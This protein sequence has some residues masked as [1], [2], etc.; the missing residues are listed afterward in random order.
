MVPAGLRHG[1]EEGLQVG[2][3]READ[4]VVD[5]MARALDQRDNRRRIAEL[6]AG[7]DLLNTWITHIGSAVYAIAPGVDEGHYLG[8]TLLEG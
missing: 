1:G 4:R 8:Q 7:K 6:S 5:R 2:A 3:L